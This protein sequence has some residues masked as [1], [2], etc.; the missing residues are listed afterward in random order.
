V[1]GQSLH[2][3][4][5]FPRVLA[6]LA[7]LGCS[8]DSAGN[9][10]ASAGAGAG[11]SSD[12]SGAGGVPGGGGTGASGGSPGGASG[13]AG[14][15]AQSGSTG[16]GG[17]ASGG[18]SSGGSGG[19][20]ETG[21]RIEGRVLLVDGVPY[22]VRGVC[23]NPV[24]KGATHPAGLDYAGFAEG[25]ADLMQAAGINTV[26]TYE[27]LLDTAVL[28]TLFE[29]GIRVLNS[30][31]P[32]GGDPA[33][34]V[35]ERVNAVK[36]HPATLGYLIGNEWNYNGLYVDLPHDQA[37]ARLN[38]AAS[39]IRAADGAHPIISVYG[40]LPSAEV[41]EAMPDVDIW[42]INVYRGI[43]FGDLFSAWE[44]RSDK[45]MIVSEYGADAYNSNLPGYDPESQAL[46]VET[47]TK[48]L[49]DESA[50]LT[51]DGVTL[52][53]TI[54]EFA[55]E[56]W[57]AENPAVQD[58]GGVAPGGGPYPDQTFNEEWWGIV[59]IDRNPRPAYDALKALYVPQRGAFEAYRIN[60][61]GS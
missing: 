47:L 25:D 31:Y 54:F 5:L 21:V 4:A 7:V 9:G 50:A 49:L 27:P 19:S 61:K 34:V 30:V 20:G 41:V 16:T 36:D 12:V 24:P 32:Y 29:R 42:G 35:T 11:G 6:L 10:P 55:D 39:L 18:T 14:S 45:P 38:E 59:D 26:R 48:A 53:G 13:S 60:S 3:S 2:F 8:D 1:S 28:D 46:A 56:W 23:W 17:A 51:A 44:A 40:E 37:L 15:G 22:H 33:S 43:G 57:K 58:T 52:G